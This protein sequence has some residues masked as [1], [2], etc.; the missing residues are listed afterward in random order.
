M[1]EMHLIQPGFTYSVRG[2]SQKQKKKFKNSKQQETP[3]MSEVNG[4]KIRAIL[5]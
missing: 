4:R 1:S 5:Y 3:G 2:Y